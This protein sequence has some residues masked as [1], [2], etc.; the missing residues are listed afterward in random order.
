MTIILD[1][2]SHISNTIKIYSDSMHICAWCNLSIVSTILP[3]YMT[4][5]FWGC[6]TFSYSC[7]QSNH[8]WLRTYWKRII[9]FSI[10]YVEIQLHRVSKFQVVM[11][12]FYLTVICI[13]I[14][15]H[16]SNQT[17]STTLRSFIGS[18]YSSYLLFN[19]F[20][21]TTHVYIS[22]MLLKNNLHKLFKFHDKTK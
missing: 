17:R 7:Y 21:L 2:C 14:K 3:L 15:P 11:Y 1:K 13:P 18:E 4:D 19:F 20:L 5:L 12:F 8:E 22:L 6:G 10:C 9:R 16:Q